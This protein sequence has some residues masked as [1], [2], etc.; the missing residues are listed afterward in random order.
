MKDPPVT[1]EK[2]SNL[3]SVGPFAVWLMS[4]P[5]CSNWQCNWLAA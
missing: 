5:I 3:F 2:H 1:V 4:R